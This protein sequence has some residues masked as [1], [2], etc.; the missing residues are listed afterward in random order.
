M[1]SFNLLFEINNREMKLY[2]HRYNLRKIY[3]NIALILGMSI[4]FNS[5]KEDPQ[6]WQVKSEQQVIGDFI[7]E[8]PDEFSEFNKLVDLAGMKALLKIRGPYTVFLPTNEAMFDFYE[9]KGVSGVEDFSPRFQEELCR[10]HFVASFISTGDI[11]LGALNEVNGLGDYLPSEFE[12]SDIIIGKYSKII[13]RNIYC[14]NGVVQ[15]MDKVL[16]PVVDDIF[17]VVSSDPSYKIFSDGLRLTGLMDTLRIISFPYG[18]SEARTRYTILAVA[19]TIY[20]RYGINS[21]EDLIEWSGANPDSVTFLNNPF[22]R[23]IE[24]HCLHGSYYLS[25]LENGVYPILSKDNN[26]AFRIDTDYK[27]NLDLDTKLYTGFNIPASNTPAKNGA[28]HS[29]DDILAAVE[30][31]AA[32]VIFE[33][34][35]FFD[36][37]QGDYYQSHFTRFFDGENDLNKIKWR[38]NYLQY[39]FHSNNTALR[40]RDCLAIQGGW[41]EISIT[42]PKVMAGVYEIYLFQPP[43]GDVTDCVVSVDGVSTGFTYTGS[44]GTGSGGLQKVADVVFETTAEH[45]ITIRNIMAGMVF[46]DY[47]E[48]VPVK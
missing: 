28:L 5:C 23:Y 29:V 24:Y 47:V 15:V 35:D 40:S 17:T 34:T 48:F 1:N 14:S 31:R 20:Q 8:N 12:G 46:W 42:F 36:L 7:A 13:N 33:T 25:N 6:L 37:Q 38:G 32:Q 26:V 18:N 10:N 3:V 27:I 2:M 44:Y 39:Y 22:Y 41:W 45:T 16:D 43:W 30:P 11:G 4:I 19:D 21:V 9:L